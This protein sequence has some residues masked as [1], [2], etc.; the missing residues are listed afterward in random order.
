MAR[1]LHH[2]QCQR[3]SDRAPM[4]KITVYEDQGT[5]TLK[6]EGK[7]G[8]PWVEELQRTWTDLTPSLGSK[9][10]QLDLRGLAFADDKGR[11]LLHEIYQRTHAAFLTDSPLT[12]YFAD[13]AMQSRNQKHQGE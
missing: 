7:I 6:L 5:H 1:D 2:Q 12:K 3:N 11:K 4:L 9:K 13:D 8:G 10:L